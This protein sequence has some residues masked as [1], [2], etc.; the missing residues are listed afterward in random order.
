MGR[1]VDV[2]LGT[3]V[4]GAVL[5]A[6]ARVVEAR[7]GGGPDDVGLESDLNTPPTGGASFDI[8]A[9]GAVHV[10]DQVHGRLLRWSSGKAVPQRLPLPIAGTLADISIA[11]DGTLY[12]LEEARAGQGPVLRAFGEDGK[13]IGS[14]ELTERSASQVQ[15]G[16]DGPVVLQQ[17]SG[18][19]VPATVGDGGRPDGVEVA[20]A[21]PGRI[22]AGG[23][24]VVILRR[25]HEI[26]AA[27]G[28]GSQVL[29]SWRVTSETPLAEVQLAEPLGTRLVLVVRVYTDVRDEFIVL[30]LGTRGPEAGASLDS[31]DWAE[32]APLG[33]FRLAGSSLYQLGSTPTGL[34]VDRFD[35]EVPS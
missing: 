29:R 16:V 12:L 14:V 1:P 13:E 24:E 26:R 6:D 34:F 9:G 25:G 20:G 5:H 2:R 18:Q 31:A 35:L 7:W 4:F 30:V 8:D 19:W 10:L 3:H 11:P 23:D 15:V 32:T 33:R 22:L 17:P 28:R 27:I 21:R